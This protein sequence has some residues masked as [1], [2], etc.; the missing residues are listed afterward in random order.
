MCYQ[1]EIDIIAKNKD[2]Y[3]FIEVKTRISNKYGAPRDSVN[4]NKQKHIKNSA[5]YYIYLNNL[6]YKKIRFDVVEVYIKEKIYINH[7][8]NLMW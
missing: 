8:K 1:G 3:V 7:L 4:D 6:Q 2:E 5:K